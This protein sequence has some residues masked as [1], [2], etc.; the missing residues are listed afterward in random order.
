MENITHI[1]MTLDLRENFSHRA[2][3]FT[4]GTFSRFIEK[5]PTCAVF[6]VCSILTLVS[7]RLSLPSI[8]LI[9]GP[10]HPLNM[11]ILTSQLS[12]LTIHTCKFSTDFCVL[13][14]TFCDFC[15]LLPSLLFLFFHCLLRYDSLLRAI[16]FY[17]NQG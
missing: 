8:R 5:F 12:D 1:S 15:S 13:R 6:G 4:D 9:L 10:S 17:H 11:I 3:I 14:C 2:Y 16:T 7:L